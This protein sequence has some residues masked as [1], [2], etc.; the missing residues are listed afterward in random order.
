MSQSSAS[1]PRRIVWQSVITV[2]SATVLIGV[3]VFGAAFAGGWALA[4]LF[5]VVEYSI[6]AQAIF[7]LAGVAVMVAFVR[8]GMRVEPFTTR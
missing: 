2:L 3:E 7:F 8:N 4:S 6:Y 1:R 5:G